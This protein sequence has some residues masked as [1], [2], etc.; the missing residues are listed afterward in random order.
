M[1]RFTSTL[2]R[3]LAGQPAREPWDEAGRPRAWLFLLLLILAGTGLYGATIGGW[4][5]PLQAVYTALKFPLL[6]VLTLAA[7]AV[8][9]GML[10]QRLGL[11]IGFR[12]ATYALLA[13]FGITALILAAL[14]PV[15]LFVLVHMPPLGSADRLLAHNFML[16]MHVLF[17]AGAGIAGHARLYRFLAETGG[18]AAIARR[19]LS[20]W[21]AGNLFLGAQLAW[22]L[23]PFVGA[24]HLPVQWLR[25][26]AWQGNCYESFAE[27]LARLLG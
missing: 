2:R 22:I 9:N 17:I 7:N 13:A 6:V 20:A 5:A 11:S 12:P 8:L 1:N 3:L 10:A 23:R 26:D 24:P 15:A 18:N 16:L 25:P 19:V 4:R 14:S 27:A 21:L